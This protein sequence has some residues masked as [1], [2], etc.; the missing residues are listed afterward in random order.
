MFLKSELRKLNMENKQA[1][2][3]GLGRYDVLFVFAMETGNALNYH[4]VTFCGSRGNND[5]FSVCA[6]QIS[7][8]LIM[9]I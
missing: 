1:R 9:L 4:V 3:Y 6:N 5:I 8:M 2:T 7:N